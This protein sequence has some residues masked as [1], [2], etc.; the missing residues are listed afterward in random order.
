MIK[1]NVVLISVTKMRTSLTLKN[2]AIYR[3]SA[4][5]LPLL[6]FRINNIA[7]QQDAYCSQ[8]VD[9]HDINFQIQNIW[10]LTAFPISTLR[11]FLEM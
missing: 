4:Y 8:I 6:A 7:S 10:K 2:V 11:S 5:A 1:V 3:L 9:V